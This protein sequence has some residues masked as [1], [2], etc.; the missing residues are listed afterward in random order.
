MILSTLEN[1]DISSLVIKMLGL[2]VSK[3]M[4]FEAKFDKLMLFEVDGQYTH[5]SDSGKDFGK[6]DISYFVMIDYTHTL[7]MI[8]TFGTAILQLP[9]NGGHDGGNFHVEYKG[10]KATY[11]DQVDS[12]KL[13]SLSSFYD[14]CQYVMKPITRGWKLT[15]VFNLVW[16]NSTIVMP[17]DFLVFLKSLKKLE[18]ALISWVPQ[19]K[20]DVFSTEVQQLLKENVKIPLITW[21]DDKIV[22]CNEKAED[23]DIE[24]SEDSENSENDDNSEYEYDSDSSDLWYDD[25]TDCH[26][27]QKIS[28]RECEE[29]DVLF[30]VLEEKYFENSLMF[31]H[32]QGNDRIL[33]DLLRCCPFI[34]VHLAKATYIKPI[35]RKTT[36][37]MAPKNQSPIKI[38]RW[39]DSNGAVKDLKIDELNWSEKCVG[40]I[41][42][43][44]GP[45][46]TETY[47][48]TRL[49]SAECHYQNSFRCSGEVEIIRE[50]ICFHTI[51]V[52][53]PKHQSIG[54]YCRYGRY[55]L[56]MFLNYFESSLTS[57]LGWQAV[58]QQQL[59]Q[60]FH[61]VVEYC[62]T[63][64][65]R[66]WTQ[67][68]FK[69]GEITLRLLRLCIA[70]RARKE[71]LQIL[72]ILGS[73]FET[74]RKKQILSFVGIQNEQVAQ[75]LVQFVCQS[76]GECFML[77]V[78][79]N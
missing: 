55:G 33:A 62:C 53:W 63:H 39:I 13:S 48:E 3:T 60:D 21:I 42:N 59:T 57:M 29:E 34:D 47:S 23:T 50:R 32:L 64:P 66:I 28:T 58:A 4:D 76:N 24:D 72:K 36:G 26:C 18:E 20:E 52:I 65:K 74:K 54:M 7:T 25:E 12:H 5:T 19:R 67:S 51:L 44:L 61:Q 78:K 70:L 75:A 2:P 77:F 15:L 37:G 9:V 69:K 56:D 16:T 14:S 6:T 11:E 46:S 73:E 27:D 8:G 35:A 71:G 22:S 79:F 43:L 31:H 49:N 40:P 30:F 45:C 68:S 17:T 1:F 41:R 38:L 10:R